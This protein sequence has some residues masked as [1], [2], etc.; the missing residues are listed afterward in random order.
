MM[1][2]SQIVVVGSINVDLIVRVD[3]R[4]APGET[5]LG[6]SFAVSPG[7]KGANQAVA[8]A[9]L[10]GSVAM[11]GAVGDDEYAGVALGGLREAGVNLAPVRLARP[12]SGERTG[13]AVITV[14]ADGDNSIVVVPGANATVGA[15]AVTD[16]EELLVGA[17]AVVV[18]AEIPR[19][20]V[21][22]A[23]RLAGGR[24]VVNLAPAVEVNPE[25]L[26]RADPLVVNEHEGASAL[27]LLRGGQVGEPDAN[28]RRDPLS[29]PVG[30]TAAA[31]IADDE[32]VIVRALVQEGVASVV[33]TRGA[34]GCVVGRRDES[35]VQVSEIPALRVRTI[36][37]T[38]AGDAFVGAL[39]VGL[40][41]GQSLEDAARYATRVAAY[42]V[43]SRGAQTSYPTS[44][45]LGTVR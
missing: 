29:I 35:G 11:V 22:A 13:V 30:M 33:L 21:E 18:Q 39:T 5:V 3:R 34:R 1:T 19:D 44:S 45:E 16:E 31:R 43:Q 8:A 7:G 38:G 42:S 26:L 6:R 24:L 2:T 17:A 15:A 12:G 20:G 37:T 40:V 10:G 4:P 25:V 32:A 14:D 28:P 36:D 23:A 27:A 9:R 41:D